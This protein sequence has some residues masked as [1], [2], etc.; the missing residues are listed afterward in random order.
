M[1]RKTIYDMTFAYVYPSLVKKAENKGRTKED[2]DALTCWLTGYT[3]KD[4][5]HAMESGVSYGDF[6][7]H[8]PAVHPNAMLITGSICGVKVQDIEDPIMQRVR[9]L[10]K[11]VDELA[12]GKPM[13]KILRK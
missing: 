4:I 6:F 1:P 12:K 11:L 3:Q 5:D 2:V 13:E 7:A 10:D 9:W 8:A